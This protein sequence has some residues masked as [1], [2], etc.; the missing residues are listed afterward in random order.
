MRST[1]PRPITTRATSA[2][3][4]T[5]SVH[6]V[7]LARPA[8]RSDD[9]DQQSSPIRNHFREPDSDHRTDDRPRMFSP[10]FLQE[11]S[12]WVRVS[13]MRSITLPPHMRCP[14]SEIFQP[15]WRASPASASRQL[16]QCPCAT[17]H[18]RK[19]AS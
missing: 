12:L 7:R 4:H 9:P 16:D 10:T 13:Y 5:C 18:V 17:D 11:C 6:S 2:C 14:L 8:T 3:P 19:P 1:D 15:K